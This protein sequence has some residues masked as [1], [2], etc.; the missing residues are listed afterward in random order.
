MILFRAMS[1]WYLALLGRAPP[2][3]VSVKEYIS[4]I[5]VSDVPY[6][7]L[8]QCPLHTRYPSYLL[9]LRRFPVPQVVPHCVALRFALASRAGL[10]HIPGVAW[11][12]S[13]C[14]LPLSVTSPSVRKDR[15]LLW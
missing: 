13:L 4:P 8:S 11:H 14:E 1:K 9:K 3:G 2:T 12:M 7:L 5:E 15:S 10:Y 6:V